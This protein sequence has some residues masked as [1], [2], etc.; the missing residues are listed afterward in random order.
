M[1]LNIAVLGTGWFG[2]KHA[3]LLASMEDVRIAGFLGTSIEKAEEAAKPYADA[4]GYTN[5]EQLLDEQKPD[6]V[7]I[8]VPP[9]AHGAIEATLIDRG[10][11]F[12][13]EKPLAADAETPAQ[14][15]EQLRAKPVIHSVGYHIR[16]RSTVDVLKKELQESMVGMVTGGW[17]GGMPGVHWWRNQEMSGGQF[18]E[19]TTHLVDLLR[20]TLG[21]VV[22]VYAAF[23]NRKLHAS[24][25]GFTATDVG[26]VTLKLENGA[27]AVIS[28]TCLLPDGVG[29]AD[30]QF[31]TDK[32]MLNWDQGRL[33]IIRSSG[34]TT[35][36]N[37]HDPYQA[38]NEAFLHAVRT[39][40]TSLIR[41]TYEDAYRTHLVTMAANESARTGLPV[42][43]TTLT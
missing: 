32:A 27:V 19:Q 1:S 38:E 3:E 9:M 20:Y 22:E 8:T 40:D 30:M 14:I 25:E 18:V 29:R 10:I 39:G 31:Y 26:T 23:A 11:P 12:L 4:K 17:M 35:H 5:L 36:D 37:L 21:E 15:L 42:R 33:E 16:Y 7:Y 28:N 13:V 41:S 6:A 2:K 24:V 34:S 43:I